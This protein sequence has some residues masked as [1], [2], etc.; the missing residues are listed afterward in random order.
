MGRT[1]T[2]DQFAPILKTFLAILLAL[3]AVNLSVAKN[4]SPTAGPAGLDVIII[5]KDVR[6]EWNS[7]A[8]EGSFV[9]EVATEIDHN[10]DL[11]FEKLDEITVRGFHRYE[12]V[13]R[14]PDKEGLRYYRV[15]QVAKG[16]TDRSEVLTANFMFKDNFTIN[17]DTDAALDELY[18]GVNSSNS[19]IAD[20]N[21]TSLGTKYKEAYGAEI[22]RGFNELDVDV[23]DDL[24]LGKYLIAFSLNGDTQYIIAEKKEHKEFTA[25]KQ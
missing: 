9:I 15:T 20:I 19:G 14:T 17:F 18:L 24:P 12:Y 25:V 5:D 16:K 11:K 7:R 1:T 4:T 3:L 8:T 23:K 10:G 22:T 2:P 21:I 13:D 6:L